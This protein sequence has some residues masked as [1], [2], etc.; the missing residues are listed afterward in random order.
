M[1]FGQ[2]NAVDT[3][4]WYW[5]EVEAESGHRRYLEICAENGIIIYANVV[6]EFEWIRS[7]LREA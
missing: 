3:P 7:I 6:G 4:W 5:Y 1:K 2:P